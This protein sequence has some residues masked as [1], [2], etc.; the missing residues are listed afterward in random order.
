MTERESSE[1]TLAY[2]H[3]DNGLELDLDESEV[4]REAIYDA[5]YAMVDRCFVFMSLRD[6]GIIAVRLDCKPDAKDADLDALASDFGERLMH[7]ALH[8]RV[9]R[10]TGALRDEYTQR[11]LHGRHRDATVAELLAELDEED[12]LD[13]ELDVTVPWEKPA[14]A[15]VETRDG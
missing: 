14:G 12:D 1:L 10:A 9:H 8:H 3:R 13:D 11:A 15:K 5:C 4:S 6:D 2:Q 7:A